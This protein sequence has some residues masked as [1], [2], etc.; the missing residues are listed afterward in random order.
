M[1]RKLREK[2]KKRGAWASV[3]RLRRSAIAYPRSLR[4][5]AIFRT[6]RR[7]LPFTGVKS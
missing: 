3:I 2:A 7:G 6:S 5:L 1:D 4:T